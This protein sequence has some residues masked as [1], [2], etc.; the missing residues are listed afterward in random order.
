MDPEVVF[1]CLDRVQNINDQVRRQA[2]AFLEE[3][4][5][6]PGIG[7]LLTQI[8]LNPQLPIYTRQQGGI[9]L[10]KYVTD[11][12]SGEYSET[13]TL[14]SEEDKAAIRQLL[15]QGL[16]DGV[17]KIRTAVAMVLATIAGYE[18]P[19]V[20]PEIV[21][22]LVSCLGSDNIDLVSGAMKALGMFATAD[23]L[24]DDL[25]PL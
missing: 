6:Q 22:N 18:W 25:G 11:H 4:A 7:P 21:P 15:P 5:N 19:E 9:Y 10:K 1:E 20:W 3:L 12:W 17:S 13:N 8:C 16:G 23:G 14:T 2:E 24:H